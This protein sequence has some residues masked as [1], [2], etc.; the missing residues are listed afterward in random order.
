[1]ETESGVAEQPTIFIVDDDPA[2]RDSLAEIVRAV[3]LD[4]RQFESAEQFLKA[5]RPGH[6]GCLVL[7]VRMSGMDGLSL[8]DKLVAHDIQIPTIVITG[9]GDVSMSVRAMKNGVV[10]F[11]EKPC[12]P[13]KLLAAIRVAIDLNSRQQRRVKQ[14]EALQ[15]MKATLTEVEQTVMELIIG[16]KTN[17]E[18][19]AEL[20]VSLRT[21]Q[22][23]RAAV[24]KKLE[25]NSKS[26]LVSLAQQGGWPPFDEVED[27][28][29]HSGYRHLS[30]HTSD[31][32]SIGK[33]AA[34]PTADS[35]SQPQQG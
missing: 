22:F 30:V 8:Y 5:F 3:D 16:G 35:E 12:Q 4:A 9:H 28:T 26:E 18:V 33:D 14:R 20:D 19:A 21:V 32:G 15:A 23:R 11:L 13:E 34:E 29:E 10:D 1:M 7:D 2:V 25:V 6:P 27:A 24:M 31:S 17:K